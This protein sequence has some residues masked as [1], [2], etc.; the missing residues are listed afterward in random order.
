MGQPHFEKP[1]SSNLFAILGDRSTYDLLAPEPQLT[2]LF[3]LSSQSNGIALANFVGSL[4]SRWISG[5][6]WGSRKYL[7][8]PELKPRTWATSWTAVLN[9]FASWSASSDNFD[10]QKITYP[11]MGRSHWSKWHVEAYA[12][13]PSF[14]RQEGV[15]FTCTKRRRSMFSAPGPPGI[16]LHRDVQYGYPESPDLAMRS[17]PRSQVKEEQFG[18]QACSSFTLQQ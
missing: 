18:M 16:C 9:W 11:K 15:S 14:S 2:T 1:R 8:K 6:P 3:V 10:L 17:T 4:A 5:L 12:C 13:S 7:N